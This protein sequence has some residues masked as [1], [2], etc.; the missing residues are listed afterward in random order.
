MLR[1]RGPNSGVAK[2]SQH[3]LGKAIDVR[4]EGVKTTALRD[5]ALAMKRGG[6]GFYEAS[7]F[8]HLDTGRPRSW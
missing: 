1:G 8:V 2:N 5:K 3:L 6:V 4:L 7:D